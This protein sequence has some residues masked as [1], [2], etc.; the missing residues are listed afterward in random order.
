MEKTSKNS[1]TP[2]AE[3]PSPGLAPWVKLAIGGV[4]GLVLAGGGTLGY[5]KYRQAQPEAPRAQKLF[6]AQGLPPG[7]FPEDEAR[8]VPETKPCEPPKGWVPMRPGDS[9]PCDAPVA[10]TPAKPGVVVEQP[11]APEAPRI[12]FAAVR[13]EQ[14]R[15]AINQKRRRS[16]GL[17]MTLSDNKK[18]YERV[19]WTNTDKDF[20]TEQP[21]TAPTFPVDLTRVITADRFIPA[22]VI[23]EINS[24]LEGKVVAQVEA[25]V[26]GYHGRM[27]LV[28]AGSKAIGRY[29]PF[30]KAGESRLRIVWERIIT[31]NGINIRTV[32]AEMA[33][34]MG[35]SGITGEVDNRNW[36]KYGM[37]VL[38]SIVSAIGQLHV[39][40]DSVNQKAAIDAFGR[41]LS[42]VTA[43]ILQQSLDIKPRVT[44]PAGSRILISPVD[45][46]WFKEPLKNVVQV[47]F[48]D[49][50]QKGVKR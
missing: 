33:D 34:A 16:G 35:R 30:K 8:Q 39:P 24:E 26:Y 50:D 7:F 44:I 14:L 9:Y 12:D 17:V 11:K 40:A 5:L 22:I 47:S 18:T 10:K 37:A 4:A 23:P 28:P 15:E 1:E 42:R 21:K 2:P 25:N 27:I 32:S 38:I 36:D 3:L 49:K 31:P 19:E 43:D 13:A 46:I 45:D 41:E 29:L 20:G 48:V 6:E